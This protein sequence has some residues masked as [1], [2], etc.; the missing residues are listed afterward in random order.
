MH[1]D[2]SEIPDDYV[3]MGIEMGDEHIKAL[4]SG[5]SKRVE[6]LCSSGHRS[7][8]VDW[9]A[10]QTFQLEFHAYAALRVPSVVIPRERN[11][12]L[13]PAAESFNARVLW[14]E[15]FQFDPRLFS[16]ATTA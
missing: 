3:A 12:V 9:L 14:V 4:S 13:L 5:E 10:L 7:R 11:Y 1:L 16:S 2:K 8:S 15:P 6:L